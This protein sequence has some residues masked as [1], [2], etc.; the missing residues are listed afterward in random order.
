MAM[1]RMMGLGL[2]SAMLLAG[3]VAVPDNGPRRN[4]GYDRSSDAHERNAERRE[5]RRERREDQR[6]RQEDRR[7]N[8]R[9]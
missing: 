3:C 4:W 9:N 2:M 5:D 6:E 1:T 7:D 8:R